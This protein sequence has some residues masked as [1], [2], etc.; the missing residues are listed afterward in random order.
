MII[1]TR[2]RDIP[3]EEIVAA[4]GFKDG[5]HAEW[6]EKLRGKPIQLIT[7]ATAEKFPRCNLPHFQISGGHPFIGKD[8]RTFVC[9]HLAE[10]GD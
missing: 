6:W 5:D 3:W 9:G 7:P 10:I 1:A 2:Y 8:K 4:H